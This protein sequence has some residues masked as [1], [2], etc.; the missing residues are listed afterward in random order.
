MGSL[1]AGPDLGGRLWGWQPAVPKGLGWSCL[2]AKDLQLALSS[3]GV[4]AAITARA[5][6]K[7]ET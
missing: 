7:V 1:G 4:G 6:I 2:F 5:D 3:A